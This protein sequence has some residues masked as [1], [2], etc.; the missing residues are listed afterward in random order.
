[1]MITPKF[2][3]TVVFMVV[4]TLGICGAA[5]TVLTDDHGHHGVAATHPSRNGH[6]QKDRGGGNGDVYNDRVGKGAG[7][8]AGGFGGDSGG[9]S[10]TG[11]GYGG[12]DGNGGIG[13]KGEDGGGSGNGKKLNGGGGNGG[14]SG[15]GGAEMEDIVA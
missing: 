4:S 1:M 9:E 7:G 15:G 3:I 11:S 13:G 14:Y 8:G 2:V 5:R 6:R 12:D 10:G